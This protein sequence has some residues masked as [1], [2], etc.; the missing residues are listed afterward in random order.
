M[1]ELLDERTS[2]F[3][4]SSSLNVLLTFLNFH[5]SSSRLHTRK[6]SWLLVN[7]QIWSFLKPLKR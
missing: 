1:S 4:G 7:F 2:S 3:S 5:Y 6:N